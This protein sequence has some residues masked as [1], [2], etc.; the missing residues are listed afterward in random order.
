MTWRDI[1]LEKEDRDWVGN[2]LNNWDEEDF[3]DGVI[4]SLAMFTLLTGA[5]DEMVISE[6]RATM[7]LLVVDN[8]QAGASKYSVRR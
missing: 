4:I 6:T 2:S 8:G 5:A 7:R 1:A 3:D